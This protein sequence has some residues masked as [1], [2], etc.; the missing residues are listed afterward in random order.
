MGVERR[1][2]KPAV[3]VISLD[4]ALSQGEG[5]GEFGASAE[6][7]GGERDERGRGDLKPPF[8]LRNAGEN[9]SLEWRGRVIG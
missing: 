8:S 7:A 5:F 9:Q 1:I 2:V 3:L 4:F 6:S